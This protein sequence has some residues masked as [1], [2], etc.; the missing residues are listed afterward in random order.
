MAQSST[1]FIVPP[2]VGE[3]RQDNS[4]IIQ[5]KVILTTENEFPNPC[6]CA[7]TIKDTGKAEKSIADIL[8]G[9]VPFFAPC[10]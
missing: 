10:R 9:G 4:S 1:V 2:F 3:E 7:R 8:E 6:W 5:A